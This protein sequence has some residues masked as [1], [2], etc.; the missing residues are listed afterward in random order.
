MNRLSACALALA[1]GIACAVPVGAHA[2]PPAEI[3]QSLLVPSTLDSAFAPFTCRLRP[4][5]PVCTGERHLDTGWQ[6]VDWPCDVQLH[7]RYVSDR[8]STRYYD[9]DYLNYDRRVRMDDVDY[10]STTPGGPATATLKAHVRFFEP[11]AVP[12]DVS[13]FTVI[14][15]GTI[16]DIRRV[17]GPSLFRMVGTL[18]EP[19]GEVG[20]FSGHV[21]SGGITTTHADEPFDVVLPEEAFL[22]YVCRAAT[23]G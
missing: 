4:T 8:W 13:T 12:G 9:H 11:F 10:F 2:D 15:T 20:T 14:T 22:D 6:P 7:N 17:G 23:T 16:Y 21:T 19:P 18:V 5:G 3:D 1:A